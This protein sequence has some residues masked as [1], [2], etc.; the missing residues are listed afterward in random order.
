MPLLLQKHDKNIISS[1]DIEDIGFLKKVESAF[2]IPDLAKDTTVKTTTYEFDEGKGM[3]VVDYDSAA[4][5]N[6]NFTILPSEHP[7][8]Q[9]FMQ[10]KRVVQIV[11]ALVDESYRGLGIAKQCY[12]MLSQRYIVCSD[13]QQTLEGA[14][15]WYFKVSG[16]DNIN[17]HIVYRY[18]QPGFKIDEWARQEGWSGESNLVDEANE[19]GIPATRYVDHSKTVLIAVPEY[20]TNPY[21]FN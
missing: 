10:H 16:L 21:T 11:S 20:T 5:A 7:L 8:S 15:L 4:I 2:Q 6:F 14:A 3:I 9:A 19:S 17:M 13:E 12:S 18:D 1:A